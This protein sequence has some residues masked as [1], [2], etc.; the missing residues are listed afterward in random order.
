[1]TP[2]STSYELLWQHAPC[3]HLVTTA[4]G[5]IVDANETLLAWTGHTRD[6]LLGSLFRDLL[7]PGS[8]FFYETRQQPVLRL[9]GAVRE[10]SLVVRRADGTA[11]PILMNAMLGH[12]PATT[13]VQISIFDATER[14]EYERE[15][16]LS[17][18]AAEASE[19]RVRVLQD[20]SREFGAA[21]S[22]EALI[23]ALVIS[24]RTALSATSSAVMLPD[25]DGVLTVVA[26]GYPIGDHVRPMMP[27]GVAFAENRVVVIAT[28]EEA[29]EV[30][31]DLLEYM[32]S[33]RIESLIAVP[34]VDGGQPLGVIAS[35]FARRRDFDEA[36]ID[37]QVALARQAAQALERIRLQEALQEL[38]LHDQLTGLANR[39]LLKELLAHGVRSSTDDGLALAV[40]FLDLDGFKRVNDSLGHAAGDAV[41][42]EVGVR[43]R[44][45]VREGDSIGRFGGDEF[46]IVCADAN[47]EI[48]LAVAERVR[49]VVEQPLESVPPEYPVSASVGVAV[50][51]PGLDRVLTVDELLDRADDAMYAAKTAGKNRVVLVEL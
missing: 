24:A 23:D 28:R 4:D 18:R 41:L 50:L 38:A 33:N 51:N 30:H 29:G 32:R 7:D 8:A 2:G 42:T 3:G 9:N 27:S 14:H 12:D 35:L 20:A 47:A 17:Q 15:L 49:A 34:L 31:E 26:G 43:L 16:L 37:L 40:I 6:E 21:A 36:T 48:A 1:M 19:A 46:V 11:F 45:V 25:A 44:S 13:G 39:T 22:S 10:V 5:V